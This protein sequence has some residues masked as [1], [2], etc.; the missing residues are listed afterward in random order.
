MRSDNRASS[1]TDE[2]NSAEIQKTAER[3]QHLTDV[4]KMVFRTKKR[5]GVICLS[6]TGFLSGEGKGKD[7]WMQDNGKKMQE[8]E[9]GNLHS[10]P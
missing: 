1:N 4:E 2:D 5:N 6:R 9:C 10:F 8:F 3:C 7:T